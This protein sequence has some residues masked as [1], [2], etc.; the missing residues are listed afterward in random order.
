MASFD[1]TREPWIPVIPRHG[2]PREVSLREALAEADQFTEI[3]ADSPLETMAL[4]RLLQAFFLRLFGEE[5]N[6]VERWHAMRAAGTFTDAQKQA[7]EEYL[8][9]HRERF[10]LL[11]PERP[12]YQHPEPL[13]SSPSPIA[14]LFSGEASGNNATLFDHALDDEARP[15]TLAEAARGLVATQATTL[16]G[17]RSA[18]FYYSDAPL[19][20]GAIFWLRG[21]SLFD[22]LLLNSPPE[23]KS[24]IDSEED[25]EPV[26]E[27]DELPIPEEIEPRAEE[28]YLDYLTWQSR[29][30]RLVT[31]TTEDGETVAI[32]V[33]MSQGDKLDNKELRDPLMA[34][35]HS[36]KAGVFPF[37]L[38]KGRAL[39]RDAHVFYSRFSPAKGGPPPALEWVATN[40]PE[41][42]DGWQ[43]DVFGMAND[44]AKIE[45]WRHERMPVFPALLRDKER[46]KVVSE[47]IDRTELQAKNLRQGCVACARLLL[48]PTKERSALSKQAREEAYA[49]ADGLDAEARYWARLEAPFY[50]WLG[51]LADRDDYEYLLAEWSQR[52][53]REAQQAY[54]EATESLDTS[55]RHLRARTLGRREVRAPRSYATILNPVEEF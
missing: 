48:F 11:H 50:E 39:W 55:A 15:R 18:P 30:L 1:L 16:G 49:L 9:Q 26:W 31:E 46:Q 35:R 53:H 5:T 12:F 6:N 41:P 24:R 25:D 8:N 13:S 47:A 19:A 40:E 22:A 14:K 45:L 38:R 2:P 7:I 34:Y 33:W 23:E 3:R 4:Y 29:L 37:K 36:D 28:G 42:E 17:G 21:H 20:G 10:D 43:A 44:K 52:L 27:R 51:K 32:A 54:E